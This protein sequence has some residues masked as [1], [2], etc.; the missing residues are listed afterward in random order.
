MT[1]LQILLIACPKF[2]R[3]ATRWLIYLLKIMGRR[4]YRK[5]GKMSK[6]LS[7][8][9]F[10]GLCF[11][12]VQ[13]LNL[14]HMSLTFSCQISAPN[15]IEWSDSTWRAIKEK[16]TGGNNIGRLI[17]RFL[18]YTPELLDEVVDTKWNVCLNPVLCLALSMSQLFISLRKQAE[19]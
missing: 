7:Q 5:K 1:F 15:G 4:K 14:D 19:E 6:V 9:L 17:T 3:Y 12:C 16:V 8:I 18:K 2:L 10:H 13:G 11:Q